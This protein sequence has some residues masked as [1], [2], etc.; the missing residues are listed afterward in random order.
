MS[1]HLNVCVHDELHDGVFTWH[2]HIHNRCHGRQNNRG[3]GLCVHSD[4]LLHDHEVRPHTY[5][6]VYLDGVYTHA[7]LCDHKDHLYAPFRGQVLDSHAQKLEDGHVSID[8][9]PD[10]LQIL[11]CEYRLDHDGSQFHDGLIHEQLNV[12]L[13]V[14]DDGIE[15]ACDHTH[16]QVPL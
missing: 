15:K 12:N 4:A 1:A 3:E 6:D 13:L 16:A 9:L 8:D 5:D 2:G 10:A 14:L 11:L 7:L